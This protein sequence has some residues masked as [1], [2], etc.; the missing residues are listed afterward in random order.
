NFFSHKPE[1]LDVLELDSYNVGDIHNLIPINKRDNFNDVISIQV[2]L[3]LSDEDILEVKKEIYKA[4]QINVSD[5]S[6]QFTY[7]Q[8]YHFKDSIHQPEKNQNHWTFTANGK[9]KGGK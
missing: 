1:S 6:K 3:E 9:K 8:V 4:S 7:T 5:C 2:G